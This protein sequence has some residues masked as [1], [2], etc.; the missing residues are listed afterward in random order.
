M[1]INPNYSLEECK[2]NQDSERNMET[3]KISVWSAAHLRG[4]FCVLLREEKSQ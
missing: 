3:F 1:E 2:L 4:F